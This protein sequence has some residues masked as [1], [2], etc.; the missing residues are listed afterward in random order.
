MADSLSLSEVRKCRTAADVAV[1]Y[2]RLAGKVFLVTGSSGG[3]GLATALALAKGGAT[4]AMACRPGAKADAAAE[5]VRAAA[6]GG[7]VHLLAC[8]L[9][10]PASVAACAASFRA[11]GLPGLHA[12]VNNAGINGVP[13]FAQFTPGVE[14]QFAVNFLVPSAMQTRTACGP[15]PTWRETG[16]PGAG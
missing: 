4:V 14:T 11:L 10:S 15:G 16:V 3:L 1:A 6:T 2:G 13:R 7:P 9:G 12:L 8:D 5:T